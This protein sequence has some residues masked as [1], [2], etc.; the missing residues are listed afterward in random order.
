[1]AIPSPATALA[2]GPDGVLVGV[3]GIGGD[4]RG[5]TL[6]ARLEGPIDQI[7]PA[8]CCD[9]PP[10]VRPLAYDSLLSFSKSPASPDT[11]VPD[12]A[13]AS[14]PRRTVGAVYTFRL[15]PGL[16]Y[17][18]GAPV[19]ASDFVRGLEDAAQS[20]DIEAVLHRRAAGRLAC[21]GARSCNLARAVTADD[22]AGTVTL[23]LSHP[24][25]TS[26]SRSACRT[27]RRSLRAGG[28]DPPPVRIASSATCPGS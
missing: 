21:P 8:S 13:L 15:R 14:P 11:L 12:L 18:T 7:D 24:D 6:I 10:D 9:L 2:R 23:H 4:H 27:S 28:S 20:S 1:V 26:C 19:R 5:G 25:P 3:R 22:R 17:S 16:R